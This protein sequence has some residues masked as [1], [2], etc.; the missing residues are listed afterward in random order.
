MLDWGRM[1]T[2]SQRTPIE[3]ASG[4]TTPPALIPKEFG[5]VQ[6]SLFFWSYFR[7][8]AAQILRFLRFK[9]FLLGHVL[10]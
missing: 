10:R 1:A 4:A 9:I 5:S 8:G 2:T 7:G 3:R 6:F